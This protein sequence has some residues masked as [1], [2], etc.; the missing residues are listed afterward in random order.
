[1]VVALSIT[2]R[3]NWRWSAAWHGRDRRSQLLPR[4]PWQSSTFDRLRST[5]PEPLF[6]TRR[7]RQS[8]LQCC[9]PAASKSRMVVRLALHHGH[10][11]LAPPADDRQRK[12]VD[13][14][15]DVLSR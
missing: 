4:L 7:L 15:E 3:M 11:K 8:E 2:P 14:R 9:F 10:V 6:A 13:Q 5:L 1:M 12:F